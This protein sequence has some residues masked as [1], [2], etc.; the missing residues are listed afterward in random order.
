VVKHVKTPLKHFF[1]SSI[2]GGAR[3]QPHHRH[4]KETISEEVELRIFR[5]M[6]RKGVGRKEN[7]REPSS[8]R[9][10][11]TRSRVAQ[12]EW[13]TEMHFKHLSTKKERQHAVGMEE[14]VRRQ[15]HLTSDV[16]IA[17]DVQY[18]VDDP[19]YTRTRETRYFQ[20]A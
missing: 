6:A 18:W 7:N 1:Y 15:C 5:A 8:S 14:V 4:N 9:G 12:A 19:K 13:T 20:L 2:G 17:R 16:D 3:D 11:T 10:P